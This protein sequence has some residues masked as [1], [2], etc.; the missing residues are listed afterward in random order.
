MAEGQFCVRG[1]GSAR[2]CPAIP[3][4]KEAITNK[5][6]KLF[7]MD[8]VERSCNESSGFDWFYHVKTKGN[9]DSPNLAVH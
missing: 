7:L 3:K 8:Q 4:G 2:F 6:V 9:R 5:S 1:G